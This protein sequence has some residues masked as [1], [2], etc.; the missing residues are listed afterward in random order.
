MHMCGIQGFALSAGGG[1]GS[2]TV[3]TL[4]RPGVEGPT[5]VLELDSEDDW[6]G[7]QKHWRLKVSWGRG[8]LA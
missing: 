7:V 8:W 6:W 4:Y 1:V 5:K 2:R 3:W